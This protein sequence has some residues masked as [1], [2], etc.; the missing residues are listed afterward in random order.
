LQLIAGPLDGGSGQILDALGNI[1]DFVGG[2]AVVV[3]LVYL[4]IQVRQNNSQ[5]RESSAATRAATYQ[6]AMNLIAEINLE[7]AKSPELAKFH[8]I[9]RQD[10]D[11]LSDVERTQCTSLHLNAMRA[12]HHIFL[13]YRAGL[14]DEASWRSHANGIQV[15]LS[16]SGPRF[17]YESWKESFSPGFVAEVDRLLEPSER[18]EP[19]V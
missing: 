2:V 7:I 6:N 12:Q 13:Q 17:L 11:T 16:R 1:G 9:S 8:G 3:T 10:F 4:A 5:L 18:K 15:V 19:A 14:I